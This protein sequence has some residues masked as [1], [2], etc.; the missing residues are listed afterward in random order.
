[1]SAS[2]L[3]SARSVIS[4]LISLGRTRFELFSTELREELAR[5]ATLLL[6]GLT[7]VMLGELGIAFAAWALIAA[8]GEE[9]RL[10]ATCLVSL[11]FIS[12]ALLLTW[13]LVRFARVK[14]RAFD[15]TLT[16]LARDYEG[17]KP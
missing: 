9:H 3:D 4:D 5:L 8:V 17:L 15:A 10:L 2:L 7:A 13:A 6:G 12:A 1:M 11:A 16:E 14:Q